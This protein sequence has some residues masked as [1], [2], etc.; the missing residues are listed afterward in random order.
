MEDRHVDNFSCLFFCGFDAERRN[1]SES[2][3]EIGVK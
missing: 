3:A 1:K 2:V